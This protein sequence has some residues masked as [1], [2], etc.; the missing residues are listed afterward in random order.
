MYPKQKT[1]N[2]Y[3]T[4]YIKC[5]KLELIQKYYPNCCFSDLFAR[6]KEVKEGLFLVTTNF[7]NN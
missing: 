2:V 6:I 4:L 5:L 3:Q 1:D 7:S